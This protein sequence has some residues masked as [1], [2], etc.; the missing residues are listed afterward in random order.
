MRLF[1]PHIARL[2]L[3]WRKL[4]VNFLPFLFKR[5]NK[6]DELVLERELER[7]FDFDFGLDLDLDFD[8]ERALKN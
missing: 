4:R 7:D 3:P 1:L 5:L 8:L 2:I 6:E